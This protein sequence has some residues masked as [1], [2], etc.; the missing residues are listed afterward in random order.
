MEE[1]EKEIPELEME[2]RKD[3]WKSVETMAKEAGMDITDYIIQY[4]MEDVVSSCCAYGCE[5]EPD[6]ICSH[7]QQSILLAYGMI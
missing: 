7:G 1:S 3:T 6:G 2:E 5:V 4:A